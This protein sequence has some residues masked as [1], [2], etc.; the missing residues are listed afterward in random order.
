MWSAD[1]DECLQHINKL[2]FQKFEVILLPDESLKVSDAYQNM[3]LT[4]ITTGPVNPALKRDKGAERSQGQFLVFIDDDAYPPSDWLNI[5]HKTLKNREDIVAIGGPAST[6]QNDPFW[7]RV[8]G[9]VFLSQF[10]GGF[11]ERYIPCPPSRPVDDWPT[12]NL[13]VS[14][15][16]FQQVGG[17]DSKFWPGE[18]THLCLK[19][20]N[21]TSKKILYVPEML[22]WHHRRSKLWKHL[23]Q[24][25]NYGLHRGYFV[26]IFP[27][28]SKRLKYFIPTLWVVFVLTG[29]LMVAAFSWGEMLYIAGW[30]LYLATLMLSWVDIQRHETPKVATG[31]IP[32][33]VLTHLWYGLKFFQG[34]V[35]KK[36]QGSLGR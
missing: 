17:F 34:L 23:R 6:P 27:K 25:G 26:K 35:T 3:P 32:F 36:L 28:T 5:A 29:P 11:P 18:D 33:I 20:I 14:R 24:V 12:V 10:S 2:V 8:S 4:V 9:A 21:K 30:V 15:E 19:I 22:V 1:L 16:V 7:A 31:A 13:I